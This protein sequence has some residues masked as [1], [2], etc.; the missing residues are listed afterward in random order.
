MNPRMLPY[1]LFLGIVLI[2]I[3]FE[4]ARNVWFPPTAIC[5]DGSYS[6]SAHH[7]G[8]C[9]WHHGVRAWNPKIAW[10]HIW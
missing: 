9:S 8:T 1:A 7:R 5:G 10:W 3:G 2:Y 4:V 6:W